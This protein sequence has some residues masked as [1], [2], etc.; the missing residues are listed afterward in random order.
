MWRGERQVSNPGGLCHSDA[1]KY[2]ESNPHHD[3]LYL[4]YR[5]A[6]RWS[7]LQ[8]QVTLLYF[9][10]ISPVL[11][12][13]RRLR[14]GRWLK[15]ILPKRRFASGRERRQ[16]TISSNVEK[17]QKPSDTSC[18]SVHQGLV[19]PATERLNKKKKNPGQPRNVLNFLQS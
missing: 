16:I 11:A 10:G 13:W 2:S 15:P 6:I 8:S 9:I 4:K 17:P 12:E 18:C 7:R 14:K 3:D 5:E 19:P 1:P